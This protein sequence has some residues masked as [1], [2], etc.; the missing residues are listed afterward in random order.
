MR[1]VERKM[2]ERK[3]I[4]ISKDGEGKLYTKRNTYTPWVLSVDLGWERNTF[5]TLLLFLW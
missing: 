1:N 4:S 5:Y 3:I 2:L